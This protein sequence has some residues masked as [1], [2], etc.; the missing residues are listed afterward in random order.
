[1]ASPSQ[2]LVLLV[3]FNHPGICWRDSTAWNRQSRRFLE[4]VDEDF[5][6][7]MIAPLLVCSV[8]HLVVTN[9]EGLVRTVKLQGGLGCSGCEVRCQESRFWPG[10]L[11]DKKPRREVGPEKTG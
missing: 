1:M 9:K 4:C 2:A 7:H 3:G 5:L 8:L 10:V 6:L 11:W